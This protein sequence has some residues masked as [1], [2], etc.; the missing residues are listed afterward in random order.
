VRL[1]TMIKIGDFSKLSQVSVK[2]LRY[3]DEMGLLCPIEVDRFTGYR[4]YSASQLPRLNRIL[5]LK[6]LGLTLEQIAKILNDGVTVD[7]LRGMLMIKQAE[8]QQRVQEEVERLARV[9]AR[10]RQIEMENVMSSYE[11]VIK[12]VG[13]LHV[14]S[15]RGIVP[16]YAQQGNLWNE[17]Y[18]QVG[19][20]GNQF[21]G[22]CLTL[23]YDEEYKERDVD[24]E[25][26]Q[27]IGGNI[28]TQGNVK[29]QDLPAATMACTVHHGPFNTISQAYSALIKWIETNGYRAVGAAREVYLQPPAQAGV[30]ND[31]NTVTEIQ[32]PVEKV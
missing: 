26:C 2:T 23:Y 10:L 13:P 32:F 17:L 31:P 29:V 9:E 21:A 11:V 8:Q 7:Q 27:P 12:K 6:D 22:A 30:Q 16:T 3:Y 18:G 4:Y 28:T 19:R 25:V 24:V 5:A 20:Y 15:V 14:A 1:N